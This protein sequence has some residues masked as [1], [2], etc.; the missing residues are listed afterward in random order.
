MNDFGVLDILGHGRVE[1]RVGE[2]DTYLYIEKG[3]NWSLSHLEELI[4]LVRHLTKRAPDLKRAA[5]KSDKSTNPAVS[6]G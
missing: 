2:I 1:Y 4:R 3:E 5:R 6:S